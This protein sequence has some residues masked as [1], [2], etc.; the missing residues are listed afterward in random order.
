M[1]G[2][3]PA[4]ADIAADEDVDLDD[5]AA[6]A[7]W[8]A[9]YV[10][11]HSH[12][13]TA[14]EVLD[15]AFAPYDSNWA[16]RGSAVRAEAETRQI[17]DPL[18]R[19]IVF[20]AEYRL[21][22]GFA[23]ETGCEIEPQRSSDEHTYPPAIAAVPD[24]VVELWRALLAAVTAPGA[25]AR[26]AD[27]LATRR[28]GNVPALATQAADAYLDFAAGTNELSF[29][30]VDALLRG[31]T[32]ARR[33]RLAAQ[34]DRA[35]AALLAAAM[36]VVASGESP[37]SSVPMLASLC[38]DRGNPAV[39]GRVDDLLVRAMKAYA[40]RSNIVAELAT[41]RRAR[42]ATD[43]ERRRI[44]R[45]EAES[46]LARAEPATGA[47]RLAL[48]QEAVGV[49][50]R[51]NVPDVRDRA[52]ALLQ[53]ITP[54]ELGLQP[55]VAK[56]SLPVDVVTPFLAPFTM[57]PDWRDGLEFFLS[58]DSPM[59]SVDLLR[60]T[61]KEQ[62]NLSSLSRFLPTQLLRH[63]GMPSWSPPTEK[64]RI[65]HEVAQIGLTHARTNGGLLADGL[66]LFADEYGPIDPADIAAELVARWG[67]DERMAG[68]LGRAFGHFWRGDYEACV[69]VV[70]PQI[71]AALRA[72]LRELDERSSRS[73]PATTRAASPACT[74]CCAR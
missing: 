14:A 4:V 28:D 2:E 62:R 7:A 56:S 11:D 19:E 73:R 42:A 72:L 25:R 51:R 60:E 23:S 69:H 64:A 36:V 39:D 18:L 6:E 17:G 24:P 52:T 71:E 12:V 50:R 47:V 44:D 22:R 29:D 33:F 9:P 16:Y 38:A 68:V 57:S 43:D 59:G 70:V 61:E 26:L 3:A 35:R 66:R 58:T 40:D 15:A 74:S 27:L 55:I 5:P 10:F 34:A 32:L 31:W 46:A 13:T 21:R 63:D 48:L 30:V 41:L 20:V 8:R 54:G 65:A 49:A 53:R 67:C 45:E 1:T 37:G